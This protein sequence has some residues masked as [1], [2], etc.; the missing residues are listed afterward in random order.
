MPTVSNVA[1]TSTLRNTLRNELVVGVDFDPTDPANASYISTLPN[2]TIMVRGTATD[3]DLWV[4]DGTS[5]RALGASVDAPVTMTVDGA[6]GLTGNHEYIYLNKA[7]VLAATLANPG[8][9]NVGRKITIIAQTAQANTLTYTAGFNG[10]TT[11]SDVA[12][13]TAAIG[14]SITIYGLSA[15]QWVALNL[16]GVALG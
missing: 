2:G 8:A 14:N 15:T 5:I 7:G 3:G 13:W 11:T 4:K 1:K 16:Q 12:T 9:A 10:N 6:V